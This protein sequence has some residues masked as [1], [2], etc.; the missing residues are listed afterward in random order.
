M[1]DGDK[2]VVRRLNRKRGGELTFTVAA[3]RLYR[4]FII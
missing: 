3:A 4:L 2:E 1:A